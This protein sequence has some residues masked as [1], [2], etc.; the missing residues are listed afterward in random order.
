M[1]E[2]NVTSLRKSPDELA[3]IARL[4][5]AA[6]RAPRS[7]LRADRR[8]AYRRQ[9]LLLER[10]SARAAQAIGGS[11]RNLSRGGMAVLCGRFIYP[12]CGL[13]VRMATQAGGVVDVGARVLSCRYVEGTG[14]IHE[15][16]LK[17]EKRIRLEPFDRQALPMKLLLADDDLRQQAQFGWL[18]EQ[19]HAELTAWTEV[20]GLRELFRRERF[21][22]ALIDVQ[23]PTLGGAALVQEVRTGGYSSLIFAFAADGSATAK[24]AALAA[25]CD[26]LVAK[27]LAF[28]ALRRLIQAVRP[29]PLLSTL[30]GHA[31]F[32]RQIDAFVQT[33]PRETRQLEEAIAAGDT[34]RCSAGLERL[35]Q[36]GGQFGFAPICA[37]ADAL[38]AALGRGLSGAALRP[39]VREV[40]RRCSFACPAGEDN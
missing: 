10:G 37:A 26:A 6:Q 36:G 28:E 15:V 2:T 23:R 31:E 25:G 9:V 19:I 35:R 12:G 13:D 27:P 20:A 4:L 14:S 17:F 16:R 24:Q 34:E 29:E 8:L 22:L 7:E 40:V 33:L 5:D 30:A 38:Q 1:T 32:H 18:S 39:F 3:R 11:A 21:D